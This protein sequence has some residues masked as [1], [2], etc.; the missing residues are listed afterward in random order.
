MSIQLNHTIVAA[1]DK[2]RSAAFLA[3]VLGLP[4]PTPLGPFIAVKVDND[5]TLDFMEAR[6]DIVPQHYAFLIDESDFDRV[7]A[8]IE[9][10][11][12]SYWARRST[13]ATEDAGSTSRI[14]TGT[15]SR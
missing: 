13:I 5:V 3:D 8:R 6:G 12:L 15:T 2:E 7:L 9:E 1:H 14:R 4:P 10:R 11:G